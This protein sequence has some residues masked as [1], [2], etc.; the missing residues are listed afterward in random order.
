MSH[1]DRQ[2]SQHPPAPDDVVYAAFVLKGVLEPVHALYVQD[3]RFG[4]LTSIG[5]WCMCPCV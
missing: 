3:L 5:L 4:V 1:S 2:A